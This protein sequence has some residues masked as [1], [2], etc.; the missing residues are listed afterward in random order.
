MSKNRAKL[1]LDIGAKIRRSPYF[2][3]ASSSAI[4]DLLSISRIIFHAKSSFILCSG[5]ITEEF[6]FV[7]DGKVNVYTQNI[8]GRNVIIDICRAGNPLS[9]APLLTGQPGLAHAQAMEDSIILHTAKEDFFAFLQKH[10]TIAL[11]FLKITA[12]R[13][14]T[15]I[16]RLKHAVTD[17]AAY[18]ILFT[19]QQMNRHL[20]NNIRTS[21]EEI[22]LLA[23][24]APET[25][26]RL[27]KQLKAKGIL[28]KDRKQISIIRPEIL[29]DYAV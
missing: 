27:L 9:I 5:D 4:K 24:T 7:L 13:L 2:H 26:S 19:L 8:N 17:K 18:R 10:P 12:D 23:G 29:Q 16:V 25:V 20:G 11:N 3:Q 22:G 21:T 6:L 28:T 1:T 15:M 14:S